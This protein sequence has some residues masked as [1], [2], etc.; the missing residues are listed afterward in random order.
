MSVTSISAA[1]SVRFAV[2]ARAIADG[3][4]AL[5]LV[6]PAFRTPP[7]VLGVNRTVLRRPDGVV[8]AVVS[9]GRP[10]GAVAADL[11]E[12]VVVAND[13]QGAAAGEVR[14]QLWAWAAEHDEVGGVAAA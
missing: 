14:D 7:R 8:I 3:A 13:L 1:P 11:I 6:V 5:G 12:G 2:T 9:K 4:R 10:F